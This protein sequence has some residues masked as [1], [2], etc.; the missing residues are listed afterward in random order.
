MKYRIYFCFLLIIVCL[1]GVASRSQA[2]SLFCIKGPGMQPQCHYHDARLCAEKARY[3]SKGY[4]DVNHKVV[5][6]PDGAG[7][8]CLVTSSGYIQCPY[9][10]Y[11]SC[12]QDIATKNGI[13]AR[14]PKRPLPS[15]EL[16][17]EVDDYY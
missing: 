15:K 9:L 12:R 2:E 1:T 10:T 8:F 13:C 17:F 7:Y 14:S 4:C 3:V 11:Q 5:T 6:L 16:E